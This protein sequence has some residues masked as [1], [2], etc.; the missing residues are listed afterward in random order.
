MTECF[1]PVSP[2]LLRFCTLLQPIFVPSCKELWAFQLNI[3]FSCQTIYFERLLEPK[4]SDTTP[5]YTRTFGNPS[6][7]SPSFVDHRFR[8]Q[9]RY[10]SYLRVKNVCSASE[11]PPP[12]GD[13]TK[14]EAGS[15]HKWARIWYFCHRT[16]VDKYISL[17]FVV[18][19][20]DSCSFCFKTL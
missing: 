13:S 9:T 4:R 16:F 18:Y 19:I 5:H 3:C 10:Y 11:A 15:N 17:W 7:L 14:Q 6:C 2:S 1:I 8:L 20:T 12:L